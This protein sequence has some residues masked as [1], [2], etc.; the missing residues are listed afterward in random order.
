MLEIFYPSL[1]VF[2]LESHC[3]RTVPLRLGKVQSCFHHADLRKAV[4]FNK[5]FKV[6][7]WRKYSWSFAVST[8]L[9][10]ESVASRHE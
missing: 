7:A 5:N 2:V 10:I 1:F 8:N 9:E 3:V 4:V 6:H